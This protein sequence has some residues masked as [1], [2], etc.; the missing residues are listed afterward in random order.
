MSE[1]RQT[2]VTLIPRLQARLGVLV[3]RLRL[4]GLPGER[5]NAVT[6]AL[7]GVIAQI[8]TAE[9]GVHG[10]EW[11]VA[12]RTA[13]N[14]EPL[15][16]ETCDIARNF[17]AAPDEPH[18]H[19]HPVQTTQAL[20]IWLITQ[21]ELYCKLQLNHMGL[22]LRDPGDEDDDDDTE[23]FDF[24]GHLGEELV[25]QVG[26]SER[27]VLD[28]WRRD[29]YRLYRM[30]YSNYTRLRTYTAARGWVEETD[31]L[32]YMRRRARMHG[33]HYYVWGRDGSR[34]GA[35]LRGSRPWERSAVLG[36]LLLDRFY[37]LTAGFGYRPLRAVLINSI[38]VT[39]FALIY[40]QFHLLCVFYTQGGQTTA[41]QC[42]DVSFLQS[43]YFSALAFFLAAMGEILP[44]PL[45]GQALLVLESI[46]GFLN[47]SVIIAVI[48]NRQAGE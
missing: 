47:V 44:R 24:T 1:R 2:R 36:R 12:L 9:R 28:V 21:A 45:W 38:V 13:Q 34:D 4:S 19:R 10:R 20:W 11:A 40:W 35:R 43:L 39:A 18:L 32:D 26:L 7:D 16:R 22:A 30:L 42:Q 27:V 25:R 46:W 41:S 48:I 14:V 29:R 3:E 5:V 31:A 33:L 6:A 23:M 37:W 8:A 17:G 15:L